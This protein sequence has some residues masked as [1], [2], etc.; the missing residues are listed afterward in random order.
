MRRGQRVP[1]Q[2]AVV[3]VDD[4]P[5]AALVQPGLTTVSTDHDLRAAR[6]AA[7]LAG[8]DP[9]LLPPGSYEIVLRGT[10]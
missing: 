4:L 3:G 6:V 9:G 7:R 1:D 8:E 5:L 10:A 2:L